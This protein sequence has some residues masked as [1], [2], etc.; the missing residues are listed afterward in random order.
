MKISTATTVIFG[1]TTERKTTE[2][3]TLYYFILHDHY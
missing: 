2:A 3:L 1:N